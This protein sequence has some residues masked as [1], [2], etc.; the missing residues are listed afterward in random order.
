MELEGMEEF[1]RELKQAL[2]RMPAPPGLK[3]RLMVKKQEQFAMRR[4]RVVWWQRLAVAA[5]LICMLAGAWTW[6]NA[7]Q[8]REGEEARRQVILALRI[9][10]RALNQ[11]QSQLAAHNQ[12][13]Q[14]QTRTGSLNEQE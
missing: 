10:S 11:M 12:D 8:R 5:A 14:S 7:E 1:E 2:E 9:T 3:H 4:R 6:R 13:V